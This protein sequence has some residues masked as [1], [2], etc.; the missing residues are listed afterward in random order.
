MTQ[1]WLKMVLKS[2][3]L[4]DSTWSGAPSRDQKYPDPSKIGPDFVPIFEGRS[5]TPKSDQ[6]LTKTM[7]LA[8]KWPG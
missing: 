4:K 2:T 3:S 6:D 8:K 7:S 5:K 1:K